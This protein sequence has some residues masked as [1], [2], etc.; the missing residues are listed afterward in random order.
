MASLR[1]AYIHRQL[2]LL[3]RVK[4]GSCTLFFFGR[5]PNGFCIS[6]VQVRFYLSERNAPAC[7]MAT[8]MQRTVYFELRTSKLRSTAISNICRLQ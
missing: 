4:V 6:E 8:V 2:L 1:L 3:H 7:M 5:R